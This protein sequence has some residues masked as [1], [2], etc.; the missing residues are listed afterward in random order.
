MSEELEYRCFIGGL[1]WSTSDRALKDA[2]EKFGKLLEAK[3]TI[4]LLYLHAYSFFFA[5]F[6]AWL[7][8]FLFFCLLFTCMFQFEFC[9]FLLFDIFASGVGFCCIHGGKDC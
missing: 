9:F 2:F 6:L 8:C 4:L 5:P 1:S 3:V 7:V